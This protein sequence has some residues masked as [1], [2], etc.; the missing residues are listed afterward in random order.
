VLNVVI[1][2][3]VDGGVRMRIPRQKLLDTEC[4]GGVVRPDQHDVSESARDQLRSAQKKRA[5]E[6][7]AQ[8]R[9]GLDQSQ[10]LI[11]VHF[12]QLTWLADAKRDK[13]P[14]TGEHRDLAGELAGQ[15]GR[16]RC[17][18]IARQIQGFDGARVDDEELRGR[19]PRCD[20]YFA[21]LCATHATMHG[22][23]LDLLRRQSWKSLVNVWRGS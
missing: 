9:V 12:D 17:L 1:G 14:A 13:C 8:F 19:L 3:R 20:E 11:A 5:N 23:A 2:V 16:H 4:V 15:N 22:D 7:L 18:P 21:A 6:N 10:E